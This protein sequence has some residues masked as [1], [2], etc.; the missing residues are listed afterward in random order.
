MLW[1]L[2]SVPAYIIPGFHSPF[3]AGQTEEEWSQWAKLTWGKTV[4]LCVADEDC[5]C[6]RQVFKLLQLTIGLNPPLNGNCPTLVKMSR[7]NC[8]FALMLMWQV[9]MFQLFDT[10]LYKNWEVVRC[11]SISRTKEVR[12]SQWILAAITLDFNISPSNK[13]TLLLVGFLLLN[14]AYLFMLP[15]PVLTCGCDI[16]LCFGYVLSGTWFHL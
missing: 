3:Q 14:H 6:D 7:S 8:E 15:D 16:V 9:G 13:L 4:K 11:S 2:P 1:W 10:A 12:L 5:Q